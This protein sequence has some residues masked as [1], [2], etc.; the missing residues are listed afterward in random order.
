MFNSPAGGAGR[1]FPSPVSGVVSPAAQIAE[2]ELVIEQVNQLSSQLAQKQ[3]IIADEDLTIAKTSGLQS[4][5]SDKVELSTFN[6]ENQ[7]GI[8]VVA[9]LEQ[10]IFL[11]ANAADVYTQAEVNGLVNAK[12]DIINDSDLTNPKTNGLQSAFDSKATT[13]ALTSGLSTKPIRLC[14]QIM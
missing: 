1:L 14:Y 13:S 12:Q 10:S 9:N 11:T 8:T 3:N 4:A 6:A 5:L 7:Q 2:G